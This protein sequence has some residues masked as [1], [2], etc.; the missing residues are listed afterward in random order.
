MDL[1]EKIEQDFKEALRQRQGELLE[2]LRGLK[3]AL[4]NKEIELRSKNKELG[5]EEL[6]EVLRREVKK[7]QEA[8]EMFKQGSRLDL[9]EKEEKEMVFLKQYLPE[10]LTDD[11]IKEISLKVIAELGATGK[12]DFG[13]VMG[14]VMIETNGR[15]EGNR[16]KKI[17]EE[18][19]S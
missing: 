8:Q 2:I 6:M 12:Q 5:E 14:R 1:L 10:E 7:R 9:A 4:H 13:K 11:K 16:V 17:V 3:T 19:L 18:L 15:A